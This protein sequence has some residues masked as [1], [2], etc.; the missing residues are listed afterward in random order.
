MNSATRVDEL[1]AR[2]AVG[3]QIGDRNALQRVLFGKSGDLRAAH[4]R[5]VVVDQL[6]DR[7]HR[8]DAGEPAKIDRRLG[9]AG[10]HQHAAI[11]GDQRKDMA[12]PDKIGAA[13]IVVGEITDRRGAV[14]GRDAG[15]RAVA[16]IDRNG[17]GGAVNRV[18]VGDHRRQMEPPSD[19]PGQRRADDAASMADDKRHLFRRGVD[20]GNDQITLVLAVVVIGDD[21][22]LAGGECVDRLADTGLGQFILSQT[23]PG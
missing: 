9:M 10:A 21:D 20:R 14:F 3:D 4:D 18:V 11:F 16:V 22:D 2:L 19:L 5:A 8:L 23:P 15:C 1:F 6:A 7:R 12:R 13:G 17:K